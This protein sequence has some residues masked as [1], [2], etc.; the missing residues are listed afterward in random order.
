MMY[1]YLKF[2]TFQKDIVSTQEGSVGKEGVSQFLFRPRM[3]SSL[4]APYDSSSLHSDTLVPSL[5]QLISFS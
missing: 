4:L 3:D 5:C 2:L 1:V